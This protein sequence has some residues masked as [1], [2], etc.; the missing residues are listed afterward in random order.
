MERDDGTMEGILREGV[1]FCCLFFD[2]NLYGI[3]LLRVWTLYC[4]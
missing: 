3:M 2:K 1:F 4:G